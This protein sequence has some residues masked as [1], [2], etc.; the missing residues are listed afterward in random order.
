MGS[1]QCA[2]IARQIK[3]YLTATKD[4]PFDQFLYEMDGD[5][6]PLT[7]LTQAA[8]KHTTTLSPDEH[9][10]A[11][12]YSYT[13]KPPELY[14][15]ENVA[16]ARK[17]VT[18]SPAPEFNQY[19]WLDAPIVMV[20]ARDGVKVPA[21]LFKPANFKQGRPGRGLRARRRLF[22]ERGS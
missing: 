17:K 1:A 5:G 16:G 9:W 7:R 8:G 13:N 6:G 15:R 14:I 3:F 19:P 12:I 4:G 22:A 18:T 21:R 2:A 10:I 11:D 20:P